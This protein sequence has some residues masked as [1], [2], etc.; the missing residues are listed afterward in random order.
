VVNAARESVMQHLPISNQR[1]HFW[2]IFA[3]GH[4]KLGWAALG[5]SRGGLDIQAYQ[6][7]K[8]AAPDIYRARQLYGKDNVRLYKFRPEAFI[9]VGGSGK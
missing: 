4:K 2:I 3:R 8:D 1:P 7:K 9:L 6:T 5:T